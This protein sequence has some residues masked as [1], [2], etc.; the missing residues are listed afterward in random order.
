MADK[1][2]R[3]GRGRSDQLW[4]QRRVRAALG[5]VGLFVA[6]LV[7]SAD[8]PRVPPFSQLLKA[9]AHGLLAVGALLV[10]VLVAPLVYETGVGVFRAPLLVLAAMASVVAVAELPA[11]MALGS[12]TSTQLW[13]TWGLRVVLAVALGALM[14]KLLLLHRFSGSHGARAHYRNPEEELGR[15][16]PFQ[17]QDLE[18][19]RHA[20]LAGPADHEARVV[21]LVG[22]W[23]DGKSFL[24]QR[25]SAFL[26]HHADTDGV[27]KPCA[28][29][30]VDV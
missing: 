3:K 12:S 22:R 25:L 8:I 19:L 20:V 26:D 21:Q 5:A 1:L 23:G 11:A 10:I 16:L 29:I 7:M 15:L 30:V 2:L 18:R 9:D 14:G 17:R 24:V 4:P 13:E 28:V 6:V 27:K